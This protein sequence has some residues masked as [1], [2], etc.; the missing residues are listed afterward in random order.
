MKTLRR[1]ALVSCLAL[2]SATPALAQLAPPNDLGVALGHIHLVVKNVDA[3]KEFWTTMLGG[4]MVANGPL[5]LIQFPGIFIMLRQGEAT[6]PSA[7]SI[8]NH[9]G[10]VYQDL[11]GARARWKAAASSSTSA[12]P[13]RIRATSTLPTA[14]FESRSLAIRRCPGR[15]AWITFI[16]IRPALTYR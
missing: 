15:S 14:Q 2:A 9:F 12:R 5:T 6:G 13:I 4:T 7:G 8:V 11:A 16:C 10:F 1:L 3:Q